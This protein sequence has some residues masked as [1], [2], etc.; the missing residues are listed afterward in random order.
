M[1]LLDRYIFKSVLFACAAAVGLFA[2]IVIVPNVARDLLN[3]MLAGQ[4]PALTAAK[5]ILLLVPIALV[6]ALPMGILTGVL[7]T[8]G[9]LSADSEV[10]AMRAA[11]LSLTRLARP[12]LV[13]AALS[14]AVALYFNFD[15]MPRARV[16]Y[17]S[18]FAAAIRTNPMNFIVP[19]TPPSVGAMVP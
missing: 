18:S 14:M 16:A 4:L 3:H 17:E 10:T 2:F 6:Y 11:G 9:R 8:L 13:L 19:K 1:N 15:S 5:L 12:I 7:L